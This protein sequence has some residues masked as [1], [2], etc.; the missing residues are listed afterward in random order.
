MRIFLLLLS[1]IFLTTSHAAYASEPSITG[2]WATQGNG[3]VIEIYSCQDD[4][5]CGRFYW[6]KSEDPKNPSRDDRNPDK[7]KKK[8]LLCGLEF[9]GGF[10]AQEEQGDFGTGWVYSPRHGARFSASLKLI[11][12]DHLIMKGYFLL[13]F[14]GDAQTWTRKANAD[15][16]YSLKKRL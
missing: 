5:Y 10:E 8:R 14:L 6:L 12:K 3:A 9:I 1:V 2:L 7:D 16:C 15:A 4:A 13:P 11:D